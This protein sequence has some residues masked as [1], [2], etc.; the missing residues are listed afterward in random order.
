[1]RT[2]VGIV[3]A[4]PAGLLLSHLLHLEGIESVVI[5]ARS[6]EHIEGRLR[7]G[8]LEHGTVEF[9]KQVGLGERM[10]RLGMVQNALDFRFNG[11]SHRIDFTEATGGK[12]AMV[13]PQHEV[14]KD[15]VQARLAAGGQLLFDSA[16]LGIDGIDGARPVIRFE[17]EGREQTL[18]CD[19][20]AG[21]DG[22]HG[23]CRDA[24]PASAQKGFDR[25]YPFGWLGIMAET[26]P[27]RDVTWGYHP[28]GFAMHSMRTPTVSRLYLQ[29]SP[30]DKVE[31]WSD[32]RIWSELHQRLELKDG[33]RLEEGAILQKGITSMRSFV[34][35]P[36]QYGKLFLAGDAA[37]IVP[38]TGAKGLNSAVADI[39]VLG[40]GLIDFY[41][42]DKRESLARYSEICLK[43]MWLVQRFSSGLCTMVHRFPEDSP[44]VQRLQLADLEYMTGTEIGRRE[45][46][47]NFTGLPIEA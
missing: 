40:R 10:G 6:R 7:A 44:F 9:F 30:D 28:N 24:I 11:Q 14:V 35:E 27:T 5:E 2:Q 22:F 3:G 45:F 39:R 13:Y 16:V 42:R 46:S 1:M 38:P 34:C 23:L 47:E 32:D 26:P 21:C 17:S 36:M 18:E 12:I 31:N 20:I 37:H 43:R 15:L 29:C 19:F 41:K 8:V 25:I 33:Y 4:G